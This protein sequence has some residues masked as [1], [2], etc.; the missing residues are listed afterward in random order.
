[1]GWEECKWFLTSLL[2]FLPSK[3]IIIPSLSW[4]TGSQ[5]YRSDK[6]RRRWNRRQRIRCESHLTEKR[7]EKIPSSFCQT[8]RHSSLD[9][10]SVLM[11]NWIPC[12]LRWI[13]YEFKKMHLRTTMWR[14]IW[15]SD[16]NNALRIKLYKRMGWKNNVS[17]E[18]RRSSGQKNALHLLEVCVH[19]KKK[20]KKK[21]TDHKKH[22]TKSLT[23]EISSS[24]GSHEEQELFSFVN[25]YF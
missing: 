5:I 3:I 4:V 24:C 16:C 22:G 15:E 7:E 18:R 19:H 12:S 25:D 13:T 1:M 2:L 6:R 14:S 11:Q 8:S 9:R 10:H 20:E 21:K 23:E 17:Q